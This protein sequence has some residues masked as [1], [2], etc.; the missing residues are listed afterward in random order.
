MTMTA[1]PRPQHEEA[2]HPFDMEKS[3][4]EK[5]LERDFRPLSQAM[6][7][8]EYADHLG[9]L[10]KMAWRAR[11]IQ[12]LRDQLSDEYMQFWIMPLMNSRLGFDT[13]RNPKK[14]R[15][16]DDKPFIPYTIDDIRSV[17]IEACLRG[18][19]LTDNETNIISGNWYGTKAYFWRRI[20]SFEGITDFTPLPGL[21]VIEFGDGKYGP[22]PVRAVVPYRVT[23]KIQ[24]KLYEISRDIPVKMSY[25]STDDQAIGKADRKM[26]ATVWAILSG[27]PQDTADPDEVERLE[28]PKVKATGA[29]AIKKAMEAEGVAETPAN[30][31]AKA[32]QVSPVGATAGGESAVSAAA[33]P[34][35]PVSAPPRG[36][37]RPKAKAPDEAAQAPAPVDDPRTME[38]IAEEFAGDV[39]SARKALASYVTS[40]NNRI[41]NWA[42]IAKVEAGIETVLSDATDEQIAIMARAYKLQELKAK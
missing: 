28:A 4:F 29:D 9:H 19:M 20:T 3:D 12:K 30:A 1:P 13:D 17:V 32:K 37:G 18:A 38:D 27:T 33:T 22:V 25:G 14:P 11:I 5:L 39:K 15:K 24:G 42:C 21:P 2:Q 10:Q 26:W 8:A 41:K 23:Y 40:A 7:E 31:P 6:E 34:P 35:A 36:P 16:Q